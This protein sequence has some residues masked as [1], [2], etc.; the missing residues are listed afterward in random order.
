MSQIPAA[1]TVP[2]SS[3]A[4]IADLYRFVTTKRLGLPVALVKTSSKTMLE[5]GD[6]RDS[7]AIVGDQVNMTYA[8]DL[9]RVTLILEAIRTRHLSLGLS[10]RRGPRRVLNS[11]H[12]VFHRSCE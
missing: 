4:A 9:A 10:L 5:L 2:A 12:K 6:E 11:S 7:L 1:S 8:G 3:R